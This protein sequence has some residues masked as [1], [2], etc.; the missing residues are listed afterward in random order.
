MKKLIKE[1]GDDY[2]LVQDSQ[3]ISEILEFIG[4]GDYRAEAL[5]VKLGDGE[6]CEI[7]EAPFVPHMMEYAYRLYPEGED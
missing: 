7:W 6:Y 4:L 1:F 5:F 3:E 2:I